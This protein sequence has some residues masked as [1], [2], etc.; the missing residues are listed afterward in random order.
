MRAYWLTFEGHAAGCVDADGDYDAKRIG[1]HFTK[2]KV[3]KAEGLPYPASPRIYAYDH[4]VIG[5]TPS[6]C[7]QPEKCKGSS[8]CPRSYSCVE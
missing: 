3:T 1:E 8:S 7:F 2:C 6:F 4:P 5:V